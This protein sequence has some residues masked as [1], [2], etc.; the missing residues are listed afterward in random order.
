MVG[1]LNF[2]RDRRHFSGID[3]GYADLVVADELVFE[4]YVFDLLPGHFVYG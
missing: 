1:T 2:I 3:Q 4:N